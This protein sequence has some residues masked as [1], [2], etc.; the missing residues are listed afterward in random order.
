VTLVAAG[1]KSREEILSYFAGLFRGKLARE[2]SHVWDVLV[3]CSSD[4]CPA[5]L[6]EDI[7]R[8]YQEGLVDPSYIRLEHVQHDLTTGKDQA[9]ARLASDPPRRLV[10][11]TVAE[12][13]WWACFQDKKSG[14]VSGTSQAS[15]AASLKPAAAKP[16]TGRNEP[17]PCGSGKK[18]KKCCGA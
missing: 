9:L 18:F 10:D 12:M 2:W 7:E 14:A 8:A 13:G 17:C 1:Q 4:L 15:V 6:I 5:E 3:S 11:D 16:K